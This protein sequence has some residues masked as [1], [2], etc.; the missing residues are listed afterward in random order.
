MKRLIIMVGLLTIVVVAVLFL[1]RPASLAAGALPHHSVDVAN[2]ERL[3]N[4]GGCASCHRS[5]EDRMEPAELG[6]GLAM[7]T[8]FGVF[9][10]PN[11]S[12][13]KSSGIGNWT[14]LEFAS[15]MLKG[16]SPDGRHLYPSFPYASYTRMQ[17][18]D[19]MDLKAY[20]DTLPP[21][22]QSNQSHELKFP[23]NI[24]P[25]IGLWKMLNLNPDPIIDVPA[26]SEKLQLG[27]YLVE[28]PGHCGECHTPRDWTG[29]LDTSRWLSGAAN[30]EGE[31]KVADITPGDD[32]IGDW[33]ESDIAYY[34]KSGFTPE[35]DTVGS[36]MVKVQE[37]M[38]K[39]TDEDR[40]AIAAYLKALP[41]V[42]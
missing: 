31:G 34:L 9:H 38:A 17:I 25:G 14:T 24:R 23:W 37:N 6:G 16:V 36:S 29:G 22:A 8:A 4:A 28:G 1:I 7:D 40:K 2:G 39:L 19:V 13:D 12:P 10:V 5:G 30:P 18:E 20:L 33:Q 15:A 11:I 27:R 3:F 26:G 42:N 32:G 35:Y 21:V 41:V